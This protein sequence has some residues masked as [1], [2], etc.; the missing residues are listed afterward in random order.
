MTGWRLTGGPRDGL[1]RASGAFTGHEV[2]REMLSVLT[3]GSPSPWANPGRSPACKEA[4]TRFQ[5]GDRGGGVCETG[6]G[7]SRPQQEGVS[8]GAGDRTQGR[9]LRR[10]SPV[11]SPAVICPRVTASALVTFADSGLGHEV[12]RLRATVILLL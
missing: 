5:R 8:S 12:A 3:C 7:Q 9:Q 10:V 4:Q 11:F 2:R 6:R 1:P